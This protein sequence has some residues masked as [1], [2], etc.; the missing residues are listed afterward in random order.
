[1]KC[2]RCA[3]SPNHDIGECPVKDA[4]CRKCGKKG[5]FQRACRSKK[6]ISSINKS[7]EQ[8]DKSFFLGVVRAQ[9]TEPMIP[10]TFPELPW[11]EV[12]MDLFEQKKPAYLII[13]DCYY[14]FI[15]IAQ[16]DRTTA[17]ATSDN[18][19]QEYVL[20]TWHTRGNCSR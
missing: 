20:E 6:K 7:P 1:M 14:R 11:Q 13:V 19:L 8:P 10:F 16:L 5:H 18:L 17:E 4:I 12:G 15:K 2:T 3:K 9:K